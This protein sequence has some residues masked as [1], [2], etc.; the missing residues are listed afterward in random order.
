MLNYFCGVIFVMLLEPLLTNAIKCDGWFI[1]STIYRRALLISAE[2][3]FG[4]QQ[5]SSISVRTQVILLAKKMR[6]VFMTPLTFILFGLIVSVIVQEILEGKKNIFILHRPYLSMCDLWWKCFTQSMENVLGCYLC[7]FLL[8]S[9]RLFFLLSW[10][11]HNSMNI[12]LI[13]K[14]LRII[15]AFIMLI[16]I[17]YEL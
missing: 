4:L 9:V 14:T 11:S 7:G 13:D 17:V 8:L 3:A 6:R 12:I 1:W 15:V 2:L 10:I 5:C 16:K